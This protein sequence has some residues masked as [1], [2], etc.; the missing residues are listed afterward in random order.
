[1]NEPSSH[2]D[3]LLDEAAAA[4]RR[5]PTPERPSDELVLEGLRHGD[6]RRLRS[7]P[8]T[9]YE[10]ALR[11]H[12]FVRYGLVALVVSA[13]LLIGFGS[14]SDMLLLADV[15]EAVTKHKTVRFDV[16]RSPRAVTQT[17]YGTVDTMHSRIEGPNSQ[18][19]IVDI[20]K[21]ILL[22]LW[23]DEKRAIIS[24]F[25]GKASRQGFFD[26]LDDLE[27]DKRTT[28]SPEKL[29]GSD[30]VVYRLTKEGVNSTIWVDR[31]TKLPVR[32]EMAQV[33][34]RQ[35]KVLYTHFAWDPPIADPEKFFSVE[36]PAGYTVQTKN[37]FN[38]GPAGKKTNQ[39]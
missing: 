29:D 23:P 3:H 1:M 15:M 32:L 28:S 33:K 19:M 14:R 12:P 5:M 30:V 37:L 4:M 31:K 21:G 10:R 36:P 2:E 17:S 27:K 35:D 24:K 22:R 20:T 7:L 9:L 25:P 16:N 6:R 13:L 34:G 38:D 39:P 8:N 18:V 11:M 26:I